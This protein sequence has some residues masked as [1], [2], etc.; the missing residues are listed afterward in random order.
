[1]YATEFFYTKPSRGFA[2]LSIAFERIQ[3]ERPLSD[4]GPCKTDLSA[5]PRFIARERRSAHPSQLLLT[6]AKYPRHS[7]NP[8]N[9]L[10]QWLGA[11]RPRAKL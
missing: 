9:R 2:A 1:M 3:D 6:R 10:F 4:Y 7:R 8:L 11:R 5:I